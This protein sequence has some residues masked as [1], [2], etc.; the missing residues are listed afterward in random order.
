MLVSSVS[1]ESWDSLPTSPA[2]GYGRHMHA[3]PK[4]VP[5]VYY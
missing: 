4:Q 2:T 1:E 3:L 5:A